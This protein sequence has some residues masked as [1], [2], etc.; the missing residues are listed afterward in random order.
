MV[1]LVIALI[2][3]LFISS[4][5]HKIMQNKLKQKE[6]Q[7]QQLKI[8]IENYSKQLSICQMQMQKSKEFY[9]RRIQNYQKT[10]QR[11]L[12]LKR[13]R[14][15]SHEEGDSDIV[16]NELNRMFNEN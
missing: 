16:L 12:E 4:V 9:N 13:L 14:E 11:L 1:W 7:I 10:Q 6:E 2:S 5:S 8:Q 3:V 15:Y